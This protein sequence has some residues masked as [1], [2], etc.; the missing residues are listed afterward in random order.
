MGD[1]RRGYVLIAVLVSLSLCTAL[2]ATYALSSRRA[3]EQSIAEVDRA[4]AQYLARGACVQAVKDL[5][6][7]LGAKWPEFAAHG[8]SGGAAGGR[9]GQAATVVPGLPAFPPEMAAAGGLLGRIAE[10]MAEVQ[11]AQQ[12][13]GSGA[14][15]NPGDPGGTAEEVQAERARRQAEEDAA[16]KGPAPLVLT[17]EARLQINGRDATVWF[18]SES[19]KINVNRAVRRDLRGLLLALGESGQRADGVLNAIEDFRIARSGQDAADRRYVALRL[20]EEP[21]KGAPLERMETLLSV[22]GMSVDLYERLTPHLTTMSSSSGVDPNYASGVVLRAIGMTDPRALDRVV[23][24]QRRLERITRVTFRDIVGP[25]VFPTLENAIEFN[26]APVFTVRAR[27]EVGRS[28]GRYM[29]RVR[30]DDNGLAK[31]VESRE[32]WL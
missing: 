12:N 7:A 3:I 23:E 14:R 10:R 26:I 25:G 1:P 18:E 32:G 28:T 31:L 22:P 27:A 20:L 30:L 8:G 15:R 11:Q 5:G 4:G 29:I 19:G 21:L 24:A 16:A 13:Q 17:G 9:G 6:M 2:A